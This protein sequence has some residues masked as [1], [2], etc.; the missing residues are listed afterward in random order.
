MSR[1]DGGRARAGVAEAA[2]SATSG[3][4]GVEVLLQGRLDQTDLFEICQ[5]LLMGTKTGVLEVDCEGKRG[6]LYFDHGQIVN[7]LDDALADGQAAAYR[8]FSWTRGTF[9]TCRTSRTFPRTPFRIR[10]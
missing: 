4:P 1:G 7:A 2:E 3:R 6:A 9:S 10:T 5:F 8:V